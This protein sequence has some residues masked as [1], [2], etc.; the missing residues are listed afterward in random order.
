MFVLLQ[1][2]FEIAAGSDQIRTINIGLIFGDGTGFLHTQ[3]GQAFYVE[4][5][6]FQTIRS[7]PPVNFKLDHGGTIWASSDL[8][9][10]GTQDPVLHYA[11][12]LV[13][14]Y[15]LTVAQNRKI[16]LEKSATN[17]RII[18]GKHTTFK[19]GRTIYLFFV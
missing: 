15:N 6:K 19:P 17:G 4:Y 18:N 1:A 10:V 13:G 14:V 16:I 7:S 11:G 9:L 3:N 12:H 5:N 8:R 2:Q